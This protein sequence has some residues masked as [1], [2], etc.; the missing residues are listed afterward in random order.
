MKEIHLATIDLN[1]LVVLATVYD[2]G[3]VA[4]TAARLSLTAS[5]VS[6]ALA[7]LRVRLGDPLFTR[8]AGGLVPTPRAVALVAGLRR[9]LRDLE[10][11][12]RGGG[13]FEPAASK[14]TFRVM[15]SDYGAALIVPELTRRFERE[16]PGVQLAGSAVNMTEFE[17]LTAGDADLA[18]DPFR[19]APAGFERQ[20]LLTDRWVCVLSRHHPRVGRRLSL[21]QYV[22]ARHAVVAPRGISRGFVDEAFARLGKRRRVVLTIPHFLAAARIAARSSVVFTIP[23]RLARLLAPGSA[24]RIVDPPLEIEPFTLYMVWHRERNHDPA[25][26]WLRTTVEEVTAKLP[27]LKAG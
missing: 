17:A 27:A 23:E 6:H 12:L 24:A 25:H 2:E 20:P 4:R 13:S 18:I 11:T 8:R 9:P 15:T 19:A 22:A 7:R 14:E 3:S 16:A 21:D 26:R 5:A 10:G 1:L